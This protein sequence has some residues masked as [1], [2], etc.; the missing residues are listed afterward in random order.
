MDIFKK[1]VLFGVCVSNCNGIGII[2]F[3][4]VLMVWWDFVNV[5]F[6]GV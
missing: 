6:F 4:D 5:I 3:V 1:V 2:E